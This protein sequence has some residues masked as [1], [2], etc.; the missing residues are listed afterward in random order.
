ME[1]ALFVD[2]HFGLDKT[3]QFYQDYQK[4]FGERPSIFSVQ[5]YDT[6]LLLRQTILLGADNRE[7]LKEALANTTEFPSAIGNLKINSKREFVRPVVQLSVE[8]GQIKKAH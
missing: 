6:G 1:G 5:G 2:S 8:G 3:S 7:E 4:A